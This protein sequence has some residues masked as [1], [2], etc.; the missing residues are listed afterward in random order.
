MPVVYVSSKFHAS[1]VLDSDDDFLFEVWTDAKLVK[2]RESYGHPQR[3]IWLHIVN[4]DDEVEVF[5]IDITEKTIYEGSFD[6]VRKDREFSF[7]LD[8]KA[9]VN[10]HKLTKEKI[11]AGLIP[12]VAGLVVNGHTHSVDLPIDLIIQSKKL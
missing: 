4:P 5:P 3:G 11:D 6:V 2:E 10:V 8:G 9:K 7:S 12:R 1:I